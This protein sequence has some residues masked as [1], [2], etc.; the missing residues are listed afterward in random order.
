MIEKLNILRTYPDPVFQNVNILFNFVLEQ[1]YLTKIDEPCNDEVTM[2]IPNDE[3][4]SEF[5]QELMKLHVDSYNLDVELVSL[6][7]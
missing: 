4:R 2:K 5:H 3:I 7:N 6:L 1:G